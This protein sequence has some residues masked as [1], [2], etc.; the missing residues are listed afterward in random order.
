MTAT[1]LY[2]NNDLVAVGFLRAVLG[3]E[4]NVGTELPGDD[5]WIATGFVQATVVGGSSNPNLQAKAPVISVKCW[6][7]NPGNSRRPPRNKANNLAET[8]RAGCFHAY[9]VPV[10]VTLPGGYPGAHVR[11]AN[12]LGE[13]IYLRGDDSSF[14]C[15][16]FNLQI[17][18]TAGVGKL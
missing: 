6:A 4:S 5:S 17:K 16:Q 10:T 2:P 14:A 18:W 1:V 8:I 13:P 7:R 15:Y 3:W 9:Q 11:S 12:L